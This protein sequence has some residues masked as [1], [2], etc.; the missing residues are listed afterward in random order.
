[1]QGSVIRKV[2]KQVVEEVV[3]EVQLPDLVSS[4]S[5]DEDELVY[6]VNNPAKRGITLQTKINKT[7]VLLAVDRGATV[8]LLNKRDFQVVNKTLGTLSSEDGNKLRRL[9]R[10]EGLG[11]QRRTV[12]PT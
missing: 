11:R 5:E 3:P 12:H 2:K 7:T 4:S 1:M 8:N 10:Y 6:A 9:V